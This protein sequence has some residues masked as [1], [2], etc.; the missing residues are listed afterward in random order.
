[1]KPNPSL[2]T[3]N[4]A[5]YVLYIFQIEA[6]IR[7]LSFDLNQID[8]QLIT[9]SFTDSIQRQEQLDWY[10]QIIDEMQQRQLF[11]E[12]HLEI[13]DEILVELV[14]LHN[15][16]LTVLN[17]EKYKGLCE[18]AHEALQA[19]KLKSNMAHRHDVEVLFH[20]MFMKLQLKMKQ[21]VIN[22]ETEAAMDLFRIQ[23]AYLS[24]QYKRMRSG[25]LNFIQN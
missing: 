3:E 4:V 16:L 17:D 23:L 18:Q 5:E 19:F 15:T 21:Q 24:Q 11:K 7:S 1:M 20:A 10:G 25:E 9:P 12:G 14:Y 13:V 8:T 6:M 2:Q 22:P